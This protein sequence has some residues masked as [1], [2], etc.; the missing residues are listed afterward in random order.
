MFK[1]FLI[2]IATLLLIFSAPVNAVVRHS[3]PE[4]TSATPANFVNFDRDIKRY[5]RR[6][7]IPGA[8]VAVMQQGKLVYTQGYGWADKDKK[9]PVQA[10]NLFRIASVSKIIT[11]TAVLQLIQQGKLHYDDKVLDVLNDIQPL[12]KMKA[13]K[14]IQKLTVRDL[15]LMSTGWGNS[16]SMGYD[17]IFGPLP[18]FWEHKYDLVAPMSC[19]EAARFMMGIPMVYSPGS[20]FAYANISFCYLGLLISKINHLPYTPAAY[21]QY[22]L[23]HVLNPLGITDMR[24]GSTQET[25]A[26]EVHYYADDV[27]NGLPYGTSRVLEKAYAAGGWLASPIDLVKF[28]Y[29]LPKIL[30]KQQLAFIENE[31]KGVEYPANKKNRKIYFYS[32]GWWMYG[33]QD[34]LLWI[35]HGSFAGTRAMIVKRPDGTI[36]SIIFNKLPRPTGSALAQLHV[37]LEDI[38]Y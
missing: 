29:G 16:H 30:N 21:E 13:N 9:I 1:N 7:Q 3:V 25:F 8:A 37:L 5:M 11:A 19:Y 6:Y 34:G 32:S 4:T 12:P 28:A 23:S 14:L 33:T 2:V 22:V 26:N 17:A 36:I 20:H 31:P 18:S 35:A 27:D 24:L 10:T 38:E 15:L